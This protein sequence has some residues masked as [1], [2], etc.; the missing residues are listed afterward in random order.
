[1]VTEAQEL[2]LSADETSLLTDKE[3][4]L[5]RWAEHFNS[6]LNRPSSVNVDAINRLPQV[7]CNLLL[8]E[9]PTVA[10]TVKEIKLLSSD[11]A[12]GSG[13]ITAEIYKTGGTPVAKKMTELFHIIWRKEAIPQEFKD[14]SIIHLFKR[15][16]NPQLSDNHRGISL[17]SIA[18]K[19]LARVL[20]NRLNER[21][22]QSGLLPESQY[23]FR[24][25]RRTTDMIF[26]ARQLQEKCQE[27]NMDLYMAF[28]DLSKAFDTVSREGLWK[29]MAKFGCPTKFIAM[30]RQFHDGML[31]RK[32]K[33]IVSFLI[34]CL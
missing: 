17:L 4:V 20:L 2:P 10:E 25:D 5:K 13:A 11:K 14:A 15:K 30:V 27:Q 28:V 32:S 16:G 12:P 21:L 7:E 23:G 1:M 6:A 9:F 29:I 31:A 19:V 24:K 26:T 3:T 34:H 33:M 18:G 22:E 8:D